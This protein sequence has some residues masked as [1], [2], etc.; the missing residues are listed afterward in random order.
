MPENPHKNIV[1]IEFHQETNSF[2]QV[3]TTL[4]EFESLALYYGEEV[5]TQG[6]KRYKRFQ[7]AGFIKTV[8]RHGKGRFKTIPILSAWATSGGPIE[9]GVYQHFHDYILSELQMIDQIDGVYMSLHGAMGVEGMR[10]PEC[11]LIKSVKQQVGD[12][13]PIGVSYD[14]HA[15]ITKEKVRLATFINAYQT[16]PHRDHFKVGTE[17]AQILMST[18]EGKAKPVMAYIKMPL[19]KGGGMTIDF[20]K[21]MRKIF[22]QMRRMKG[23]DSVLSVANFMSHIW[24]DDEEL[25]WSCVVVTDN[26][27][28]LAKELADELADLN[29]SVRDCKH[30]EPVSV[31]VAVKRLTTMKFRRHFGTSVFCDTSDIVAAGGPGENTL[32]LAYL[33]EHSSDLISYIPLRDS[34]EAQRVYDCDMGTRVTLKIG[35][36]LDQEYNQELEFSGEIVRKAQTDFGKTV[37][38]KYENIFLVLT[39][40]PCPAFSPSFYT[41]LGLSLWKADIVVVKN[42]FPFRVMYSLYN[43][44]T[45]N[46]TTAGTTDL[47]VFKLNYTNIPRPIYPLDEISDWRSHK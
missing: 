33:M 14:L 43:R 35:G 41:K 27:Q 47:D 46:I 44:K 15:N 19:L 1:L 8:S 17:A 6:I 21:P 2:S 20:L 23:Q 7:A 3:P 45:F 13:V 11:H 42:L 10:D 31:D 5:L 25:G 39:E 26:D 28:E 9:A 36:K 37:V 4:R 18:I 40:L 29:W 22:R 34:S 12:N 30:P 16:N 24:L 38:I 32:I